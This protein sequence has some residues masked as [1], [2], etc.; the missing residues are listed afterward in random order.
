MSGYARVAVQLGATVSGSDRA[1][2]PAQAR[3]HRAVGFVGLDD[4][5][6]PRPPVGVLPGRPQ[7]AADEV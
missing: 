4:Q 1:D 2:S 7:R 3:Q 6:L 5:P